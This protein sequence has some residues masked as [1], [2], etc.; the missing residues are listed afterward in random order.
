MWYFRDKLIRLG[1]HKGSRDNQKLRQ[2][3]W[4]F[5]LIF[6]NK[7][8]QAKFGNGE[9]C[10]KQKNKISGKE[11]NDTEIT[12]LPDKEF[13]VMVTKVFT[14]LRRRI[15]EHSW[16]H[17]WVN[18]ERENIRKD[19]TEVRAEEYSNLTEKYTRRVQQ[20]TGWSRRIDLENKAMEL[21]QKEWQEEKRTLKKW[22]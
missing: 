15:D 13:K 20:R 12:N 5:Y 11:L 6:I 8:Y 3:D 7:E 4:D 19:Q 16:E 17:S 9:T 14:E 10:S 2:E 1:N 22:R 18:K 21:T